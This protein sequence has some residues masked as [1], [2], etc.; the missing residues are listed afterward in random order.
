MKGLHKMKENT[1]QVVWLTWTAAIQLG[2]AYETLTARCLTK[3]IRTP[4]TVS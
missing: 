1:H 2:D 4:L 3:P